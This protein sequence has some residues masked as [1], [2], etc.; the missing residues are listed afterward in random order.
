MGTLRE[1]L[2]AAA[3]D[4]DKTPEKTPEPVQQVESAPVQQS[5]EESAPSTDVT[6][7]VAGVPPQE[8]SVT[9]KSKDEPKTISE[10]LTEQVDDRKPEQVKPEVSP[11]VDHKS[12]PQKDIDR[13][14]A[15]WKGEAK[16]L[17]A[18]LPLTAK[19]EI[20]RRE[21]QTTQV[22]NDTALD[23]KR[24][25]EITQVLQPH[26]DRISTLY[27]GNPLAAIDSLLN[28]ERTLISGNKSTKAQVVANIIK[29]FDIDIMTLDSM[30]AGTDLPPEVR[31]QSE[32]DRLVE[33]RL[34]PVMTYVEQQR[35]R[36]RQLQQNKQ[37][38]FVTTVQEM[39]EDSRYPY[40]EDVR[41]DMADLIE[42]SAK[43]GID[44]SLEQAYDKAT[45]MNG[46]VTQTDNRESSQAATQAALQAHQAAQ[47]AKGAAVSV[48]GNPASTSSTVPPNTDLRSLISSAFEGGGNRL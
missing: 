14:P 26:M 15:S 18:D 21:R 20:I 33:E 39:A 19:Q 46:Y 32:V 13:A 44:L 8:G 3:N 48:S 30:L 41:N 22:L 2:E 42:L 9:T 25:Q 17:W 40:F 28:V 34:R 35:E 7:P 27:K 47:R 12:S 36:E 10:V 31:Q 1:D 43:K 37:L 4:I 23:R 24:V 45:R 29:Q 16:Q 11:E 5:P 38:E 6:E